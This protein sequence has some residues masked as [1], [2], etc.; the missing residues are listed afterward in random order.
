MIS[1]TKKA[2]AYDASGRRETA[3]RRK[4]N[5]KLG[6]KQ[7]APPRAADTAPRIPEKLAATTAANIVAP[8]CRE[9]AFNMVLP[10]GAPGFDARDC[11]AKS[12]AILGVNRNKVKRF[13]TAAL[14]FA[15][16]SCQGL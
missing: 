7:A 1:P 11:L 6:R 16:V 3:R 5:N 13:R 8:S 14:Q 9:T 15:G 12:G 2:V 4:A 10:L